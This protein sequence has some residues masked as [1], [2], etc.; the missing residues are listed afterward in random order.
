MAQSSRVSL[1]DSGCRE[2]HKLASMFQGHRGGLKHTAV[3]VGRSTWFQ[4]DGQ[5]RAICAGYSDR[6][7]GPA[8]G[9][10]KNRHRR[11]RRPG[12][13]TRNKIS[14]Q[15]ICVGKG[16]IYPFSVTLLHTITIEKRINPA[17]AACSGPFPEYIT[18]FTPNVAHTRAAERCPTT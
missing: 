10:P 18:E 8:F 2:L 5:L 9:E 11:G 7:L 3:V 14:R 1:N 12:D 6:S 15:P 16:K 13:S 17:A 4:V